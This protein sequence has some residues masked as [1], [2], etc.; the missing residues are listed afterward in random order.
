MAE[1]RASANIFA[2]FPVLDILATD[3]FGSWKKFSEKFTLCMEMEA[4]EMG[5]GVMW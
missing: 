4:F 5:I 2:S 1:R 3:V